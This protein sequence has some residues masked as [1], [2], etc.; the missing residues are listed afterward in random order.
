ADGAELKDSGDGQAWFAR[1]ASVAAFAP[2]LDVPWT[3]QRERG[4]GHTLREICQQPLTRPRTA[5]RRS[6]DGAARGRIRP[7]AARDLPAAADLASDRLHDGGG[8]KSA[9]GRPERE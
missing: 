7:H 4:Y 1:L 6:R 3:E 5:P 8:G 9:P 2:L